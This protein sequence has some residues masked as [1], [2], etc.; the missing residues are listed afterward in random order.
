[1]LGHDANGVPVSLRS[2]RFG[3]Y[4]QLGEEDKASG[5][6][7]KRSS[8]P[9]GVAPDEVTLEI[10]L[11]LLALPREV[12]AHPEDGEPVE[13][14]IGRYGPYVR[15]G[16]TYASLEAGDDVLRV[17]MNRAMELLARK[18]QRGGRGAAQKPLRELGQHPE[19]GPVAVMAGRYGPY[20]KWGK[21]NA[22]IPKESDPQ[23]IGLD[24]ALALIE[25]RAATKKPRKK[26]AAPAGRAS[27]G[28]APA[29]KASAGKKPQAKAAKRPKAK[30]GAQAR[31][32]RGA[33]APAPSEEP[34]VED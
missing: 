16:R 3:P 12:G 27:A 5:A 24:E 21:V 11:G 4:V 13:A 31:G 14:G 9:P 10:A 20:V 19:G 33:K 18:A 6:K 23:A 22:T 26:P 29:G 15:H 34:L 30:P 1:M 7:P 28:K 17:G 25:A 32:G 8:L 2:G